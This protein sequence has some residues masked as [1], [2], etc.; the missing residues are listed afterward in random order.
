MILA[1]VGVLTQ[2]AS[3]EFHSTPTLTATAQTPVPDERDLL[4][5]SVQLDQLTLT[6]SL[7]AYGDPNDPLIPMGELARLLD[8]DI[9][10]FA[11]EG[12]I[13]G[14]LGEQRVS[15]VIDLQSGLARL[16][17]NTIPLSRADIVALN[18]EVYIR[19]S[20]LAHILPVKFDVS[21]EGLSIALHPTEKLPIQAR[22]ERI[23]RLRELGQPS[24]GDSEPAMVV[25]SPYRLFSPP[26]FDVVGEL[27]RDTRRSR[28]MATRY[29]L[30]FAG[31]LLYAN[32]QGYVGSDDAGRPQTARFLVERR[33]AD[34]ALPLGAT[35]ISGGDVF[36]P[37]LPMGVRSIGGRGISFTTAPLESA[38]VFNTIDLR[39]ELPLGFDVE[40]Y[41]NDVLRSGER[42][43]VHGRYEFL[44]VPLSRGINVIRIVTYGPRG[45][46]GEA[47][48]VINVG[49]GQLR[50]GESQIEFGLVDQG[51]D[52]LEFN[53]ASQPTSGLASSGLRLAGTAAYGL[54]NAI[55]L[56]TGAAV[57]PS[58][59]NDRRALGTFGIRTSVAGFAVRA[60]MAADS[61]GGRAIGFGAAG[62]P[63]GVSLTLDDTE[64]R[65]GFV[66]E[67]ISILSPDRQL[68]RHSA[69]SVDFALPP[70][71]GRRIPLTLRGA[72]DEF[73]DGGE[74]WVAS[75]R[76]SASVF[77][78]LVS[79]G[80]DYQ[81]TTGENGKA[82]EQLVGN[83][84]ASKFLDFKWQLRSAIDFN[85]L[86][87]S[88]LRAVSFTADRN[89]SDRF[90]FRLG[91]GH[92]FSE[93]PETSA[94]VGGVY[95]LPFGE[96]TFAG[97]FGL[98]N[99]DWGLSMR[100]AFGSLFNPASQRY[101]MTSPGAASS[102]SAVV[103]AYVDHD[104]DGRFGPGDEPT[105]GVVVQ[106]GQTDVATNTSGTA[107]ITGVG[108][109]PSAMLTVNTKD[110]PLMYVRD[111]PSRIKFEPR[112]GE[113]VQIPYAI[114]P[115]GEV[116]ARFLITAQSGAAV[117]LSALRVRLVK[118]GT[119]PIVGV[120][121]YDG[122]VVFSDVP[123]GVYTV[124][125]DPAQAGRLRMTLQQ[126]PSIH[127]T[128]DSSVNFQAT[129]HFVH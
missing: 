115:V 120:T 97:D 58:I 33:S 24:E 12:R 8:L 34:G 124:Q 19:A 79:S 125:L 84:T 96:L 98:H 110:V 27:G 105:K 68:L 42:T 15:L 40:L 102:G 99:R 109:G 87:T 43:P 39:G 23:A 88:E 107:L 6:D 59:L 94:Q 112:P 56:V 126:T 38:S 86:P 104:G 101:V 74:R 52:V 51:R 116:Y 73:V 11:D 129:V 37:P 21:G 57:Y 7:A 28:A 9:Q 4:L 36:T 10:V 48:R 80:F 90:S 91:V 128:P 16:G 95:R 100:F 71:G 2:P 111:T 127:V 63:F 121:E 17:G 72:R 20:A 3:T 66:D 29:D 114:Q 118:S 64:Y 65:G 62:Q 113:V 13:T 25:K 60:D 26:S 31:D 47:V 67:T 61:T 18:A 122:S 103:K 75:A 117:G 85:L 108:A 54:T 82:D 46:R 119:Q 93:N 92:A 106:G 123:P 41:V 49:G 89:L 35:R 77:N 78:T 30:R 5:Y 45:Q 83:I 70:I 14:S 50:K 1:L 76:T 32:L 81:R 69:L 44:A 22:L 53:S 55:T